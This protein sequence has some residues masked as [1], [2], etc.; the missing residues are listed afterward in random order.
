MNKFNKILIFSLPLIAAII[1]FI[2]FEP[3]WNYIKDYSIDNEIK[4][5]T[6][7][8]YQSLFQKGKVILFLISL[9]PAIYLF[10]FDYISRLLNKIIKSVTTIIQK[11]N[12]YLTLNVVF[13]FS[14][15]ISIFFIISAVF[16]F[17]I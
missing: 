7:E 13:I 3:V 4:V 16:L 12:S 5:S 8:Y 11:V 10:F 17:D 6:K 14:F 1:F 2:P 9:L 15:I